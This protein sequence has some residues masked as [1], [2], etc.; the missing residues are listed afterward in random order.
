[1]VCKIRGENVCLDNVEHRL[2]FVHRESL[3]DVTPL[4]IQNANRVRK[5]VSL[6]HRAFRRIQR[7]KRRARQ[8][9]EGIRSPAMV[10]VVAQTAHKERTHASMIEVGRHS[11]VDFESIA[12]LSHRERM[13]PIVVWHIA[14]PSLHRQHKLD[15]RLC[16]NAKAL[17]N[18]EVVE[19]RKRHHYS[20]IVRHWRETKAQHFCLVKRVDGRELHGN[21]AFELTGFDTHVITHHLNR[22]LGSRLGLTDLGEHQRTPHGYAAVHGKSARQDHV[23]L[24]EESAPALVQQLCHTNHL[25]AVLDRNAQQVARAKAGPCVNFAIEAWVQIH[26]RHE[27]HL[28]R[29]DHVTRNTRV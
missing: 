11:T 22:N 7:R 12:K 2:V 1:M 14:V 27:L 5:V 23:A 10:D 3:E 26:V 20:L 6:H 16:R 13:H 29:G 19:H 24:G 18:S 28:P 4:C 25:V 9:L 15:E 17:H 8:L 21:K